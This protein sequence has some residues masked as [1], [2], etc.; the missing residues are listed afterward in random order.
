M[1]IFKIKPEDIERLDE[2]KLTEL[3]RILLLAETKK[4]GILQSAVAVSLKIKV[5]DGGEDGRVEWTN[6]PEKTDW[7]TRRLNMFQCKAV[8]KMRR[9]HFKES[10]FAPKKKLSR[11]GNTG[12]SKQNSSETVDD[13][14]GRKLN[15]QVV[16]ILDDGGRYVYF[17]G[18]HL[19]NQTLIDCIEGIKDALREVKRADAETASVDILDAGKIAS[20]TNQNF[21][22]VAQVCKWIGRDI[23]LSAQTCEMWSKYKEHQLFNFV[24]DESIKTQVLDLRNHLEQPQSVARIL[25]NPGL[26]KSR[27]AIQAV[28]EPEQL[29]NSVIYFDASQQIHGLKDHVRELR[30]MDEAALIIVDNCDLDL[31]QDLRRE[32]CYG[33][34][35]L[36][37]LTIDFDPSEETGNNSDVV[38][39]AEPMKPEIIREMLGQVFGSSLPE[40]ELDHIVEFAE[41]Y[42]LMAALIAQ[43]RILNKDDAT[44]LTDSRL[45][46]RLLWG[47]QPH[48]AEAYRAVSACSLF[49]KIGFEGDYSS[50]RKFVAEQCGEIEANKFY[51]H[52]K[53][54]V[55]RRVIQIR[56]DFVILAPAP[57][58]ARLAAEW[59][60]KCPDDR[61]IEIITGELPGGLSDAL[62]NQI[63]KLH[64]IPRVQQITKSLCGEQGPFGRAEVL[65]TKRGSLLFRA[66]SEVSPSECIDA[67]DSAFDGWSTADLRTVI[68]GRRNLVW[69][70]E[71]LSF[72]KESFSDSARLLLKFAA[73]ENESWSNNATGQ[74][75][76]LYQLYLPGTQA[77]LIDRVSILEDAK[78]LGNEGIL[79]ALKAASHAFKINNFH[80]IGGVEKQGSRPTQMDYSPTSRQ[81]VEQYWSHCLDFMVSVATENSELRHDAINQIETVIY[82][83]VKAQFLNPLLS[84][85]QEVTK[86]SSDYWH[87]AH[88]NLDFAV[89]GYG[90]KF[91]REKQEI[92]N[93][94]FECLAP[95]SLS[96]KLDMLVVHAP[97]SRLKTNSS[98]QISDESSKEVKLLGSECLNKWEDFRTLIPDLMTGEQRNSFTFGKILVELSFK[99]DELIDE[100][101]KVLVKNSDQINTSFLAGILC[102]KAKNDRAY[103]SRVL[104]RFADMPSLRKFVPTLT[105]IFLA[106]DHDIDRCISL[107]TDPSIR[108]QNMVQLS[109]GDGLREVSPEKLIEFS[110]LLAE[111]SAAGGWAALA[112]LH[113]YSF[114]SNERF[115][116]LAIAFENI[117]ERISLEASYDDS[118]HFMDAYVWQEISTKLLQGD[119]GKCVASRISQQIVDVCQ[120]EKDR[121]FYKFDQTF[122][123]M[124]PLLF[125]PKYLN[126]VW[127]KISAALLS[128]DWKLRLQMAWLV[129]RD[130]GD[131]EELSCPMQ[132]LPHEFLLAWVKTDVDAAAI[133][134]RNVPIMLDKRNQPND[135]IIEINPVIIEI[136]TLYGSSIDVLSELSANINSFGGWGSN[137]PRFQHRVSLFEQLQ[138]HKIPEVR[139]W[140]KQELK[141]QQKQLESSR[142]S[143][144]ERDA[145]IWDR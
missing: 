69:A 77:S 133:V 100:C 55:R 92:V 143:D 24:Q 122:K 33:D 127:P 14:E 21:V 60:E 129:G 37:L 116:R 88:Q 66:F 144:E 61:A 62:C 4:A 87:K 54:F 123:A 98:G 91:D 120:S 53:D 1:D 15:P 104:D 75:I 85:I 134:A 99:T 5:P 124:M 44:T 71:K 90:S 36:S 52:I 107:L 121:I 41:G 86:V 140:A 132:S 83:C 114:Q 6:G 18:K 137:T 56:G 78:L 39:I 142:K 131:D 126:T 2:N 125:D 96:N 35:K 48:D 27:L 3:L 95:K 73:G 45:L 81:E 119:N 28:S 9:N 25:G 16:K 145:G 50:E 102:E 22:A 34:S 7:L 8:D 103:V 74:F 23:P 12:N 84:A 79:V 38:I 136:L 141:Y 93:K 106:E 108:V 65:N 57:L 105:T 11:K 58:A 46:E 128:Q 51:R 113:Q 118:D 89:K 63:K 135:S 40:R 43:D 112:M 30:K 26:G 29:R 13:L 110:S 76:Q 101:E 19:A 80:R 47:R 94:M 20:W 42:P 68:D 10:T 64:Y 82:T 32:V 17:Y 72:W 109:Y 111:H 59:W 31:H 49:S 138:K 97:W 139:K 117:L 130:I 70:L 115:S 67:L